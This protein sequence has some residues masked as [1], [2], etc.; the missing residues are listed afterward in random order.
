MIIGKN[1]LKL[2][3]YGVFIE[4]EDREAELLKFAEQNNIT[5]AI[6]KMLTLG[7]FDELVSGSDDFDEFKKL[8]EEI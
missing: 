7:K 5:E 4:A 1:Q 8:I 3:F 6:E 2:W